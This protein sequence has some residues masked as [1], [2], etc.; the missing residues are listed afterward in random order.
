MLDCT[1]PGQQPGD[2]AALTLA[3]LDPTT[4]I[5]L[6]AYLLGFAWEYEEQADAEPAQ[7]L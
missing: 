3:G 2:R 5:S 6:R 1:S 7:G 4:R